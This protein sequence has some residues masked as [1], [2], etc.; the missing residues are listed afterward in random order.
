ML[1]D[2]EIAVPGTRGAWE[3]LATAFDGSSLTDT[4][5]P[6]DEAVKTRLA[7]V[8]RLVGSLDGY[9][10]SCHA[11]APADAEAHEHR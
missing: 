2:L 4:D 3:T 10:D 1:H 6:E 9:V 8:G 5:E 7:N 11:A